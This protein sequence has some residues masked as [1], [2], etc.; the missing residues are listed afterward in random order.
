MIKCFASLPCTK[1]PYHELDPEA[2]HPLLKMS[3]FF[4]K[5]LRAPRAEKNPRVPFAE[6][7]T[8]M[9]IGA[10]SAPRK[11]KRQRGEEKHRE[12][13]RKGNRTERERKG[14]EEG[15][16]KGTEGKETGSINIILSTNKLYVNLHYLFILFPDSR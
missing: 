4:L 9:A 13:E 2:P 14:E 1:H 15:K 3:L 8:T 6:S 10:R 12:G 11:E 7:T 16:G 5:P